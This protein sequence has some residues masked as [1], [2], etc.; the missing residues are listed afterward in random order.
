M[1]A[2]YS[3]PRDLPS[4]LRRRATQWQAAKPARLRFGEPILSVCFDDFPASAAENGA[5]LLRRWR[6]GGT[7]FAAAG[8]E[9]EDGPCGM[10]FRAGQISDLID[11]GHEVGCHTF[12]HADCAQRDAFDSLHSLAQNRDALAKMGAPAP[13]TLAYPYGETCAELKA[14]LPP[15]FQCAR[16]V[17]P[18]LNRGKV[19][20]AQLNAYALFGES[21]EA[22]AHAALKRAAKQNAWMIA[23]THDVS[24]APS[25]W[26]TSEQ[27][28]DALLG[29]AHALGFSILP[30]SAALQRRIA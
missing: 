8:M 16:G 22:R 9:G 14:A 24:G 23:F 30:M 5:A 18:G 1:T 10:N 21:W 27:N 26:G 2:A 7:F 12:D 19:D 6:G 3:P 29:A 28:L 20:L 13:Q 17:L 25:P 15:R 4:K 11:Q